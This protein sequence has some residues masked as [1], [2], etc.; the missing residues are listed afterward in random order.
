MHGLGERARAKHQDSES[1]G[2]SVN[3]R[4]KREQ[5][6]NGKAGRDNVK[7]R[8]GGSRRERKHRRGMK[9]TRV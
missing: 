9:R 1:G 4:Q 2:N 8:E 6:D 7:K 3:K 5:Y